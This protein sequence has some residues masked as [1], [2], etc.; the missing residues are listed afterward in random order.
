MPYILAGYLLF[1]VNFFAE[2]GEIAIRPRIAATVEYTD[3]VFLTNN[4]TEDDYIL[5]LSPGITAQLLGSRNGL[6]VSY[7]PA[8]VTYQN[9]SRDDTWR[10]TANLQGW[11]EFSASTRFEIQ[12]AFFYTEDP[13]PER[14]VVVSSDPDPIVPPN[15]T[16]RRGR[17]K[18][19]TNSTRALME[20]NFGAENFLN[21][22]YT[23]SF[24][25]ND[26][27]QFYEDNESHTPSVRLQYWFEPRWGVE[28]QGRYTKGLYNQ[29]KDFIGEPS[30]DFEEWFGS[31]RGNH[32]IDWQA[33]GYLMYGHTYRTWDNANEFNDDYVVYNPSVGLNYNMSEMTSLALNAGYFYREIT[34]DRGES[35]SDSSGP[36]GFGILLHNLD[37]N[38]NLFLSVSGG[39]SSSD[40]SSQALGFNKYYAIAGSV[41][42]SFNPYIT[43][44]AF[45]SYR[46][47]KYLD[48]NPERTEEFTHVGTGLTINPLSWLAIRMQYSL[49]NYD[50]EE[51]SGY[52]ENRIFLNIQLQP[53][54]PYSW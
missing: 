32:R 22:S 8:Y 47:S 35:D 14:D 1:L 12:N 46:W 49:R 3:N 18:Y 39:Y 7:D 6:E 43:V 37:D 29:S 50:P 24:L 53:E 16:V 17:R 33:E 19:Y 34:N 41:A 51:T 27:D 11:S 5:S 38:T 2:A 30:D 52:T 10:H 9:N 21:L 42:Y 15:T 13:L 25:K 40:F 23:Y 48:T 4:N 54:R 36:S 44:D 45:G 26:D 20:Y 31:I 28:G